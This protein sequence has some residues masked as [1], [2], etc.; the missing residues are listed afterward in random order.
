[1]A[2]TEPQHMTPREYGRWL[3]QQ[4]PPITDG[5][6]RAAARILATV[7]QDDVDHDAA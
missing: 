1:M 5:Q 7:P 4:A 3:A 2:T 6:A